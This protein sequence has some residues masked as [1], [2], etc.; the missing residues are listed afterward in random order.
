[1]GSNAKAR[2]AKK[3]AKGAVPAWHREQNRAKN[4]PLQDNDPQIAVTNIRDI[5]NSYATATVSVNGRSK[6]IRFHLYVADGLMYA[7]AVI[8]SI[9]VGDYKWLH[10]HI[11]TISP[12]VCE[13][14]MQNIDNLIV[15]PD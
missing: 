2:K 11:D 1:M 5:G 13:L 10:P 6:D 3:K 8:P 12:K 4:R 9:N 7:E 15:M 14:V